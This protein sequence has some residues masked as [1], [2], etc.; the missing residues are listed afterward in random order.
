MKPLISLQGNFEAFFLLSA[1]IFDLLPAGA[2][3]AFAGVRPEL[4]ER[5]AAVVAIMAGNLI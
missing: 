2:A 1:N 4:I 3:Q 5:H